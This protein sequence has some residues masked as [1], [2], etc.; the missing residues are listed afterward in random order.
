[1][2]TSV[3]DILAKKLVSRG[4][5]RGEYSR[6][7]DKAGLLKWHAAAAQEYQRMLDADPDPSHVYHLMELQREDVPLEA[8]ERVDR[9]RYVGGFVF[10]ATSVSES[11]S[12]AEPS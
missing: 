7:L 11:L 4:L 8:L 10:G 6:E 9:I 3:D 2:W 1:M 5:E 12:R